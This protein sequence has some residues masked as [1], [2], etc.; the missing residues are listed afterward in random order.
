MWVRRKTQVNTT[1]KKNNENYNKNDC[2]LENVNLKKKKSNNKQW[3]NSTGKFHINYE[4]IEQGIKMRRILIASQIIHHHDLS[5]SFL[6]KS[7][8]K[9]KH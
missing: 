2:K 4:S 5:N 1:N 9:S 3:T 7:T 8:M 6:F